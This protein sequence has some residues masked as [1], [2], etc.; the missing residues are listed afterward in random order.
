[1][2]LRIGVD[3]G[4]T[5][6]ECILVDDAGRIVARHLA[7]GCN[8]NTVGSDRAIKIVT[9]ALEA[10]QKQAPAGSSLSL[11][12]L[13]M[14][15]SPLLWKKFAGSLNG[16]GRVEAHKDSLPVLELATAGQPGL[17]LHAGT[18]SFVAARGPD[19]SLHHAG[20][21]GW[22]F[23]DGGSGYDIGRR[24][25]GRA[26]LEMQGWAPSSQLGVI[27]QRHLEME[28]WTEM[29]RSLYGEN[30]PNA[31]IAAVAPAV[32]NLAAA[33][34]QPASEI[35]LA[36]AS[37]LLDLA[38]H[39]AAKLFPGIPSLA[40]RAGLSGPILNHPFLR[41]ALFARAPFSFIPVEEP[42]VEG[43]RRMLARLV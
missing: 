31:R 38:C 29:M 9:D 10:V 11:T 33:G 14:A 17:V 40:I 35:V 41:A 37:E 7:A 5:K 16:F 34:D 21:L 43:L 26:L 36:S 19:G 42:P 2:T 8:P 18:G 13:C 27:V 28:D 1:M 24:A 20:G 25:I 23:G 12:L 15:G 30:S 4:A 22:R 6:T 3:G 32:I 39:V